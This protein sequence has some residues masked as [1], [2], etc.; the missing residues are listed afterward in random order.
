MISVVEEIE[1]HQLTDNP[2]SKC[3]AYKE[4]GQV[5]GFLDYS[6][7][8]DKVEINNIFVKEEYRNRRIASRLMEYLI[9]EVDDCDN[10]TLEVKIDNIAALKLYEKYDFKIVAIRE[11]YYDGVDGYL[12]ERK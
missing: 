9:T 5:V 4:N 10:I 8:Y 2:F 12:M 6:I 1:G 7:I 3:I 11:G